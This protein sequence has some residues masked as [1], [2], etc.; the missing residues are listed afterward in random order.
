MA[1]LAALG[2]HNL[3][4]LGVVTLALAKRRY[5]APDLLDYV[6]W[7]GR[8]A[9]LDLAVERL[10]LECGIAV[11]SR[12]SAVLPGRRLRP[13]PG[14][15]LVVHLAF[16]QE[17]PGRYGTWGWHPLRPFTYT[18]GGHSVLL[19]GTDGPR[20]RVLDPNFPAMQQWPR[21]GLA[22]ATTLIEKG[23]PEPV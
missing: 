2:A 17:A 1:A 5:G 4:D 3:P 9:P 12:S 6:S 21:P 22:T 23:A 15:V 18:T 16:G 11:R 14:A 7:P 13:R 19:A 20:W 8:R 10:A